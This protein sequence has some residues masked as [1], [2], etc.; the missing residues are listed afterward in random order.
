MTR[1]RLRI[2]H[3]ASFAGNIGDIENQKTFRK[4]FE[5]LFPELKIAWI[6]FEIR[7][8]F[9]QEEGVFET[10]N[11]EVA[12]SDLVIVGGGNFFEL[13]PENSPSGT[14][15]P[16]S[17]DY[18]RSINKPIF[19]NAMG[20]D[21]GQGVGRV[22]AE[23]FSGFIGALASSKKVFL[24]FRNDGS[25]HTVK[26]FLD[27]QSTIACRSLPDHGFFAL[28]GRG[29]SGSNELTLGINLAIDMPK[30]RFANYQGLPESFLIQFARTLELLA[31][32]FT[33][34]R[35]HFIPHMFSDLEAYS[36]VLQNLSD[37]IRRER[38]TVS[39]YDTTANSNVANAAYQDISMLIAMRF[40]S[41]VFGIQCEIPTFSLVSYPQINKLI[42]EMSIR[43]WPQHSL[44]ESHNLLNERLL[45]FV[46]SY[47]DSNFTSLRLSM[48]RYLSN[49]CEQR[50]MTGEEL[51]KWVYEVVI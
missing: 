3:L 41:N 39:P 46:N 15:L 14:S 16:F 49:L 25:V 18:L 4:W 29:E 34:L 26:N 30:I 32:H 8:F 21:D 13:W 35:F 47:L 6:N 38:V 51:Y 33:K 45:N 19:I 24:S 27:Q 20:V 23:K 9:R 17:L 22:A 43:D 11:S 50:R 7:A 40:H 31:S 12:D 42:N 44:R 1:N 37:K 2:L 28:E 10:F 48:R 5:N 36:T